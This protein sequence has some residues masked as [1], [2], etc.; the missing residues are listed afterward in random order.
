MVDGCSETS[1]TLSTAASPLFEKAGARLVHAALCC[2]AET[3]NRPLLTAFAHAS[4]SGPM[5][6]I[7]NPGLEQDGFFEYP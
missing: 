6:S 5:A 2:I 4:S 3:R 1:R 7:N